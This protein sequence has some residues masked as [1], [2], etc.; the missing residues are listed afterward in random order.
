M[1]QRWSHSEG[2]FKLIGYLK[3]CLGKKGEKNKGKAACVKTE[4]GPI[5]RLSYEEYQLFLKHFSGT[6][7]S[8]RTKPVANMAHK[9]DKEWKGDY[10]LPG[11]T[12]VNGVLY[13]PDFKCNL[14]SLEDEFNI[15]DLG[16]LKYFLGIEVAK[17]R[18]GLVLSQ[19]KYT[20]DIL[21]N[22]EKLGCKPSAFLIEEGLKLD[23]GETNRVLGYLKA[24][25]FEA[26]YLS[27]CVEPVSRKPPTL[28]LL[29]L[30]PMGIPS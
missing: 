17:T 6:G 14:L 15:K 9:E 12:K 22:S 18:D 28:R 29:L 21:E 4:T 27:E 1:Q 11:G 30:S 23:K 3:W 25:H 24:A 13:V 26:P 10:I 19:Q 8:E 16:P 7:N 20:L 5:P 2:C